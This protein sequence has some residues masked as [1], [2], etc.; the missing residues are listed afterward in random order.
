VVLLALLA[1]ETV[2]YLQVLTDGNPDDNYLITERAP[3]VIVLGLVAAASA[4]LLSGWLG[5]RVLRGILFIISAAA[6]M[7]DQGDFS[8]R[9]AEDSHDAETA[10]LIRTFNRLI[11]RV[12][13][14]LA[15]QRQLVADTSHEL[16]TPLTTISGNLELLGGALPNSERAEVLDETRQEVS[17]LTRLVNDLLLLAEIGETVSP[18]RLPVRLDLL[19]K[20]VIGRLAVV[21]RSRVRVLDEPVLVLG[22]EERL[23]QVVSNLLQNALRYATR[24]TGAVQVRV[25][26]TP[27]WALLVV[28]D[29]GPGLPPGT[30]D[31]VFD[32]FSRLDKAR[33]R[34]HGGAGLGLAIVRHV[35]EAH[36]GHAWAENSPAGGARF[37]VRLPAQPS[38][39]TRKG[40]GTRPR[41]HGQ[42][43]SEREDQN[44]EAEKFERRGGRCPIIRSTHDKNRD[45]GGG[46]RQHLQQPPRQAVTQTPGA[47]REHQTDKCDDDER[48]AK[49]GERVHHATGHDQQKGGYSACARSR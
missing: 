37:S 46:T 11:E 9:L 33:S 48:E 31:R 4:A 35:A 10:E 28:D 40:A 47:P 6:D 29:D 24:R 1:F 8:R 21:E 14:V 45:G 2:F 39:L 5:G 12:D 25:E 20:S 44:R 13:R 17:R 49:L 42:A 43:D 38:W 41:G 32:R 27:G 7:T 3:R 18:E 30:L 22:D 26:T 36:G 16:R 34:A 19:A 15:A 23:G